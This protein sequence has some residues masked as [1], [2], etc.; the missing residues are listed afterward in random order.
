MKKLFSRAILQDLKNLQKLNVY[1]C[2]EMEETIAEEATDQEGSSQLG[3]SSSPRG[4]SVSS[5]ILILPK[6]KELTL[7]TLPKL[8]RICE[9][10]L[11]CDFLE[12]MSLDR[13]RELR[14]LPFYTP[15]KN[16]H[17][18][19]ALQKIK[20]EEKWWE[21]LEWTNPTLRASSNLT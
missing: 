18:L 3:T 10:K 1:C 5:D 14:R 2:D 7:S 16:G 4:S 17:P 21:T 8:K 12:S 20:V 15:N 9:G 13:C 19:P 11:I 6:L